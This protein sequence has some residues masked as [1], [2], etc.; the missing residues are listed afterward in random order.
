MLVRN[1]EKIAAK[2][3]FKKRHNLIQ[4]TSFEIGSI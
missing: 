3:D 2:L 4:K 1:I